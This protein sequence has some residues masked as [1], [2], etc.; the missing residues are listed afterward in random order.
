MESENGV[1]VE[2]EKRVV[3]EG[4][5]VDINKENISN[6]HHTLSPEIE[7]VKDKETLNS[8][9]SQLSKPK[10][11][12]SDQ[13]N[14]PKITKNPGRNKK[15]SLTQS[16]SFPT[17]GRNSDAMRRSIELNPVKPES[18]KNGVMKVTI[19]SSLPSLHKSMVIILFINLIVSSCIHSFLL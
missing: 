1:S 13:K 9:E 14:A 19:A 3:V 16:V 15:S 7:V 6:S 10:T 4:S 18:R 2:D 8:S 5:S 17:R 12:K 11:K